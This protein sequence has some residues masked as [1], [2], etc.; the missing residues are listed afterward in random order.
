M[1]ST[2]SS[3]S[4][5]RD[6]LITAFRASLVATAS[7]SG[8]IPSLIQCAYSRHF[9]KPP[10]HAL[11]DPPSRTVR[12]SPPRPRPLDPHQRPPAVHERRARG[13]RGAPG[14][15]AHAEP[16]RGV[17]V[18]GGWRGQPRPRG[19]GAGGGSR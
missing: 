10:R 1:N 6:A 19:Q 9:K 8:D 3:P 5:I 15:H 4:A 2:S 16:G 11:R 18:S 12:A 7:I 17:G 14:R 13:R